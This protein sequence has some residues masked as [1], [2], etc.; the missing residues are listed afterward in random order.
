[1][2]E[3]LSVADEMLVRHAEALLG[4][5]RVQ[6]GYGLN[7]HVLEEHVGG[8]EL[9][10]D[11]ERLAQ[12]LERLGNLA[13]VGLARRQTSEHLVQSVLEL[14]PFG[15]LLPDAAHDVLELVEM[16]LLSAWHLERLLDELLATR[17]LTVGPVELA[18]LTLAHDAELLQPLG[19]LL[20]PALTGVQDGD[21]LA[22]GDIAR[23]V[24]ELKVFDVEHA[25]VVGARVVEVGRARP[26]ATIVRR[27]GNVGREL[28]V[29]AVGQ[30]CRAELDALEAV[31]GEN[32][33]DARHVHHVVVHGLLAVV[34][35]AGVQLVDV[36][37]QG[38]LVVHLV[39]GLD[40]VDGVAGIVDELGDEVGADHGEVGLGVVGDRGRLGRHDERAARD[41]PRGDHA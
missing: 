30:V 20:V 38:G 9:F 19:T 15:E 24:H 41:G 34:A 35:G 10:G 29:D 11:V 6:H 28:A 40:D 14:C 25:R 12:R 3:E 26:Q 18:Q 17:P 8:V 39:D 27:I 7:G 33:L 21:L 16:L 23:R 1:M 32:G 36:C 13:A 5:R 37:G 2:K 22:R 4:V 31:V